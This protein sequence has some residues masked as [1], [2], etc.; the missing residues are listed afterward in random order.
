[1]AIGSAAL[2]VVL[3]RKMMQA[4]T[5]VSGGVGGRPLGPTETAVV[6]HSRFCRGSMRVA[7]VLRLHGS[8]PLTVEALQ[9]AVNALCIRH[10]VM[11]SVVTRTSGST[12]HDETYALGPSA[13]GNVVVQVGSQGGTW[14]D[15][16]ENLQHKPLA[17]GGPLAQVCVC[18][19][20]QHLCTIPRLTGQPG[21]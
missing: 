15:E 6:K 2:A 21:L 5:C 20:M 16:W 19:R 17:L 13:S 14:Q 8:H 1:M 12:V 4:R 10:P 3:L 7:L 11:R 9:S 18:V